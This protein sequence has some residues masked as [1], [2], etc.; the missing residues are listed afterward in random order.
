MT[1]VDGQNVRT[2]GTVDDPKTDAY[3]VIDATTPPH[4]IDRESKTPGQNESY[5]NYLYRIRAHHTNAEKRMR[6]KKI[7]NHEQSKEF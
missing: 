7:E 5:D 3:K 1:K 6:T 4:Q 2:R